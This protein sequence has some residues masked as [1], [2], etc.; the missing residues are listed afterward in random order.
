MSEHNDVRLL[1]DTHVA[2]VHNL[3]ARTRRLS[4]IPT[5]S[6]SRNHVWLMAATHLGV[7]VPFDA[8]PPTPKSVRA[9]KNHPPRLGTLR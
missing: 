5:G 9:A 6:F 3:G 7:S 8:P 4:I 2:A 1:G